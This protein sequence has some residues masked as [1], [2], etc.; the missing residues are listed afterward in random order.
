MSIKK[1]L[2]KL[3][4][5]AVIQSIREIQKAIKD[6]CVD[7]MAGQKKIDCELKTCSL[8]QYR[9]WANKSDSTQDC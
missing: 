9:P 8:Y 1:N 2:R 5:N 3:K 6:N 7:C 4:K